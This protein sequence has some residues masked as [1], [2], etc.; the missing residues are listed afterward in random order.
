MRL[1]RRPRVACIP[2][3][4]KLTLG[5]DFDRFSR[6]LEVEILLGNGARAVS[7]VDLRARSGMAMLIAHSLRATHWL[8]WRRLGVRVR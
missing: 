7:S 3:G 5:P 2:R 1:P 8:D 4:P 6:T